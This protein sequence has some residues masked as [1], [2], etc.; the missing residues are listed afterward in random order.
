MDFLNA[1]LEDE[2]GEITD[3]EFSKNEHLGP[4]ELDRNVVFDIFCRTESG[5]RIIIEMQKFFQ[6]YFKE[7]SLYYSSF[8]IQEQAVKGEWDFSLY[9]VYCISLL[10][11][12]LKE[13]EIMPEHYFHKVK[14]VAT[15]TGRV[16]N[17]KLSFIYLE[18]PKF[19]KKID[20]L[21]TNF[22]KWMYL[23]TKLEFL[24]RLPEA[25]QSKIFEKVMG[26][27]ELVKLEKTDRKAYEESLKKHRD[28]KNVMDTQRRE[29]YEQGMEK[30]VE[31][32]AIG[33]F[34]AGI[35]MEIISSVTGLSKDELLKLFQ[36]EGL[37]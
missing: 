4:S 14:L 24:E 16:F 22:D 12:H 31:K 25:L 23:L 30:G 34:K 35:D 20:E 26:I 17:D 10:D 21:E 37:I 2:V 33:F 27:A 7:R 28:L 8:A 9:P 18:I 13:D 5:E 11:F 29:G 19:N 3:L 1:V 32:T 6:T 36:K 15:N